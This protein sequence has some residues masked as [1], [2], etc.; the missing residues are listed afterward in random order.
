MLKLIAIVEEA[1][2]Y[3]GRALFGHINRAI[4]LLLRPTPGAWLSPL[5]VLRLGAADCKD[6]ALAK[7]FALRQADISPERL[8]LVI[9]HN[10][11][12]GE[13]QWSPPMKAGVTDPRQSDHGACDRR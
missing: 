1:R 13:D 6:Y 2:G 12:S 10:K 11:R 5:D 3:R 4:N 7:H 8:R 9:V